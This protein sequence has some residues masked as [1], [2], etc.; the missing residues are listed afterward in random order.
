[1]LRLA[2]RDVRTPR[3][4]RPAPVQRRSDSHALSAIPTD[5]LHTALAGEQLF[6]RARDALIVADLNSGQIVRWNGAAERIFGYA[7][8]EAV[9]RRVE[10]LLPSAV[11]RLYREQVAQFARC[12]DASLITDCRPLGITALTRAGDEVRLEL[13]ISPFD[14]PAVP[15]AYLLLTFRDTSC[16][17]RAELQA[18]EAAR[19]GVVHADVERRLERCHQLLRD[20]T[21]E[22]RLPVIR[23]KRAAARLV[24]MASADGQ[25]TIQRLALLAQVVEGRTDELLRS[26]EQVADA[27]AIETDSFE[28]HTERVNL[29][30]MLSRVVSM[31]RARS[32]AYRLSF[33]APQGLTAQCDPARIEAVIRDVIE[34]AI[35]R[36]PRGCWID[37]DLRRPL[38]G[39]AHI[40][41]R[42]YGRPLS[43][44][45]REK[46]AMPHSADR[47]W[48]LDRY[49]VE[50]HGGTLSVEFPREGGL[51]VAITLPTHRPKA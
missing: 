4:P 13:S 26:L 19:A 32:S 34:R 45:E 31:L 21:S 43:I 8:T 3:T 44:R 12:G 23:A 16:E 41:V 36:N 20:T 9:G 2:L 35:R 5:P 14:L 27:A 47:G 17:R 25:P 6:A 50:E 1:M 11:S 28:L 38:A 7:S 33:S 29:V 15:G 39:L 46:L 51:R 24:R 49:I 22:L 10:M 40:E 30:P 37:V 18:L 42:D 48:F